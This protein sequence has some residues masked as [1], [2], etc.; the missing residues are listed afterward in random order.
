M[1]PPHNSHITV[2][3][4]D[5][6][7]GIVEKGGFGDYFHEGNISLMAVDYLEN[8]LDSTVR[9][10]GGGAKPFAAYTDW[11]RRIELIGLRAHVYGCCSGDG[12][13]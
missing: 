13:A 12:V 7:E 2:Y 9:I 10:N 1:G 5:D 11:V 6:L 3:V 8:I 4:P